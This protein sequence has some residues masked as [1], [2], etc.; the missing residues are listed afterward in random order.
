MLDLLVQHSQGSNSVIGCVDPGSGFGRC[1]C[2]KAF[3]S[4]LGH[5]GVTHSCALWVPELQNFLSDCWVGEGP[6]NQPPLNAQPQI[7]KRS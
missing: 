7:V 6:E 3:K 1:S 4:L 5:I 2:G